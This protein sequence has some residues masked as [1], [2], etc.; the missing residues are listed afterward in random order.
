MKRLVFVLSLLIFISC[1]GFCEEPFCNYSGWKTTNDYGLWQT[2]YA[3]YEPNNPKPAAQVTVT[4][5]S[6][7]E[8]LNTAIEDA[9]ESKQPAVTV[10]N[11]EN[12]AEERDSDKNRLYKILFSEP[13]EISDSA[14]LYQQNFDNSLSNTAE[15][16][17]QIKY[18]REITTTAKHQ[19]YTATGD[20][21]FKG[22]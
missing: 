14:D 8:N 22:R 11:L 5:C 4:I 16:L 13:N 6:A 21:S 19:V 20:D 18:N 1:A 17:E 3:D 2:L 10:V 15:E 7:D 12:F 9:Q